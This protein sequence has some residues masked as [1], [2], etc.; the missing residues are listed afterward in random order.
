MLDSGKVSQGF[1][2]QKLKRR[3][4]AKYGPAVICFSS[5]KQ[6]AS[7]ACTSIVILAEAIRFRQFAPYFWRISHV[8]LMVP[9]FMRHFF[10]KLTAFST[11]FA[12]AVLKRLKVRA[13]P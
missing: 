7:E 10:V 2:Q 6:R 5:W 4:C 13:F 1:F 8:Y 12:L 3:A 11:I 9:F